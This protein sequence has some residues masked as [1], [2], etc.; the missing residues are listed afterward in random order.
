M[1]LE[2]VIIQPLCDAT[3][4]VFTPI[5]IQKNDFL[6]ISLDKERFIIE[7]V[8]LTDTISERQING[9]YISRYGAR[10]GQIAS[11]W[12]MRIPERSKQIHY[13]KY[14]VAATDYSALVIH[15][16]WPADHLIFTSP[17]AETLYRFLV[18]R[19][20]GQT[21]RAEMIARFKLNG[22]LPALPPEFIDHPDLP[23]APYQRCGVAS[24]LMQEAAGLFWEQGTGKTA[25]CIARTCLEARLKKLGKIPNVKPGLYRVL[26]MCPKN[27]RVNWEREFQRFATTPGKTIVLRGGE[28]SRNKHIVEGIRAESDCEWSVCIINHDTVALTWNGLQMVPWDLVIL[29]ES[30]KIQSES[31]K[32]TRFIKLMNCHSRQRMALTGTPVTNSLFSLFPQLEFLGEG[33]SGFSAFER[34]RNFHGQYEK[35]E[36]KGGSSIM[37][38]IGLRGVPLIQERLSRVAFMITKQEA[39][40][41]LPDK[42]Y[43]LEE[44]SMTTRQAEIY[45]TAAQAMVVEIDALLED[46]DVSTMT[47]NHILTK[48]LRLAQITSGYLKTD[49]VVDLDTNMVVRKGSVQQIESVNPKI[50]AVLNMLADETD[51]KAKQIVWCTFVE[52][53]RALS[54]AFVKRGIEHVGYN[55]QIHENHR[56]SDALKAADRVN[57]DPLCRVMIAN[58]QSAAE[59]LNILGYDVSNP[60]ASDTYV[61]HAIYFSCNWSMVQR[62][63]SEDRIHRRGTRANVRITD[64]VVPGTIDEEIR[65]RVNSKKQ[66]ALMVQDIKEILEKLL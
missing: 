22:E 63:Q 39:N 62:A 30:H 40:L 4:Q 44:V 48:L 42:V 57:N 51:L 12:V 17:E 9:R 59:G 66:K 33:L 29:D 15:H 20:F 1:N 34:F 31:S 3:E 50:E 32:R 28:I 27:V 14:S 23:L 49:D 37:K 16:V 38:L 24:N 54:E 6:L 8:E 10:N 18:I 35:T 55:E 36:T 46:A 52:D 65:A 64:L 21:R 58:P 25:V 60:E 7:A 19:F 26:V 45:R 56:V 41:G 47:I 61:N 11:A 13:G 5:D 53:V 43:D 2:Q